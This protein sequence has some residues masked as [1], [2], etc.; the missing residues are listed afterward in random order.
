MGISKILGS[1]EGTSTRCVSTRGLVWAPVR[2]NRRR[3]SPGRHRR[4]TRGGRVAYLGA[5]RETGTEEDGSPARR[6]A[7]HCY[8]CLAMGQKGMERLKLGTGKGDEVRR[9]RW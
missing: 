5:K 9:W 6:P 1:F 7:R 8:D 4:R 3:R 2:A